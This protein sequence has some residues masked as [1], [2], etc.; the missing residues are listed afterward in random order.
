VVDDVG[1]NAGLAP[2]P[3]TIR[4][5]EGDDAQQDLAAVHI[6][7]REAAAAVAVTA[8][9]H[10]I[11]AAAAFRRGGNDLGAGCTDLAASEG[12]RELELKV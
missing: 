2:L 11:L 10:Q 5:A 12:I 4:L 3:P 9:R 7:R 1:V 6:G 8:V